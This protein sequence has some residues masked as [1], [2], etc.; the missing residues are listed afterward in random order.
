MASGEYNKLGGLT[1]SAPIAQ[2]NRVPGYELGDRGSSPCGGT[3]YFKW[4]DHQT[5]SIKIKNKIKIKICP[6]SVGNDATDF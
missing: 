6:G 4:I 5:S 2:W 1:F 3:N